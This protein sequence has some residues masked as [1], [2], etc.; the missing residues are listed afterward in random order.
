MEWMSQ[1]DDIEESEEDFFCHGWEA[2]H[3]EFAMPGRKGRTD[4]SVGKGTN[5]DESQEQ[6]NQEGGEEHEMEE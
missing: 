3:K 6:G 5:L 4:S 2:E 1:V